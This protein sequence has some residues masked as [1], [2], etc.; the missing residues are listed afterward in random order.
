[1]MRFLFLIGLAFVF[2][3]S[4]S[5]AVSKSWFKGNLHTH[6]YWSDGDEFPE[7]VMDWY[8]T[9][10]YQFV[11]L[12]DHNILAEGEKWKLITKSKMYLDGFDKY[13]KKFGNKW[14]TYKTDSGRIRAKLKTFDEYRPLFESKKFLIIK[15][16][17]LTDKF[18]K[19]HVHMG[20]VNVQSV[21][22]PQGGSSLHEVLQRNLDAIAQQR[23]ATGV[24]MLQH[25]NHP[26]F[27]YSITP[28][29]LIDL[30]GERFFE[31]YNGHALVNNRGD[32]THLGTEEIWD[33]VNIAYAK[34]GKPFL[35]GIG[36]DDSH[37]FHAFGPAYSNAGRG[38]VMVRAAGLSAGSLITAMEAGDF[39]ASTGVVLED[40][41]VVD[42]RLSVKVK[43][44]RGV[45]Y[46]I[47]FISV[48]IGNDKVIVSPNEGSSAVFN[49]KPEHLFV[50]AKITSDKKKA[51]PVEGVEFET[52][53]TQPVTIRK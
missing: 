40:V 14:V 32:S 31:V 6:S 8:K 34:A 16:E 47:E 35:Y 3:V 36:T 44:T 29:D 12:S 49:M 33:R 17:E 19:K 26:N 38:W 43:R 2:T 10:G 39:Y 22:Q 46:K 42:G 52:A 9:H 37:N 21:I 11:A 4:H 48:G 15:A 1:M 18:E 7:M 24:P 27:Y 13:L 23:R 5:Q 41:A 30:N 50:R 53:W 20:V 45:R 28:E 25:L 51:N